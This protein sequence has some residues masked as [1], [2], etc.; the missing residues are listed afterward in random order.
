MATI[1]IQ[2]REDLRYIGGRSETET[3]ANRESSKANDSLNFLTFVVVVVIVIAILLMIE[4]FTTA[5]VRGTWIPFE[6][7]SNCESDI[8]NNLIRR[9]KFLSNNN[10]NNKII[11]TPPPLPLPPPPP[12]PPPANANDELLQFY[13]QDFT[14]FHAYAGRCLA[15]GTLKTQTRRCRL[16]RHASTAKKK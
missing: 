10:N 7:L 4:A 6:A 11:A 1:A 3:K 13:L 9:T 2:W 8:R 15:S 5:I 12:P 14:I 16:K